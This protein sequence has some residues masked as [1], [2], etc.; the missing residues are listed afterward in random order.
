MTIVAAW[1]S[2]FGNGHKFIECVSDSR[3]SDK[4]GNSVFPLLNSAAKIFALPII[5]R[6]PGTSG[7]F[8]TVHHVHSV[9]LAFS[10]SSLI[11]LNLSSTL[12][13]LT[14]QLASTS[15]SHIPLFEDLAA[16]AIR[17][18]TRYVQSLMA[19]ENKV[20]AFQ[21]AVFGWCP[22][23]KEY[24]LISFG[25][26]SS[27]DPTI[28]VNQ[29]DLVQPGAVFLMGDHTPEIREQIINRRN[30]LSGIA[31]AIAPKHVIEEI[32]RQKSYQ[33][34]GGT[35]QRGQGMEQGFQLVAACQPV[36]H[37]EPAADI[38]FRGL[39]IF[40]DIGAVGPCFVSMN[41]SA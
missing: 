38:F 26:T 33:S 7:F 10:G 31:F 15:P 12:A 1:L 3:V 19:V 16:L 21:S 34:I 17:I 37:G 32:I 4:D 22:V 30:G 28:T 18:T 27:E 41:M 35:L 20:R 14:S 13:T 39:S 23:A 36:V 8:D 9:G 25:P 40:S 5:V 11:G 24:K 29:F 2:D 6:H